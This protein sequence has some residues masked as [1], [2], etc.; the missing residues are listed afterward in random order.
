MVWNGPGW[1]RMGT[2]RGLTLQVAALGGHLA[3]ALLAGFRRG[4]LNV[5]G[6]L[7]GDGSTAGSAAPCQRAAAVRH[8]GALAR[9]A[10]AA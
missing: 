1:T 10:T 9:P 2:A 4:A 5:V 3:D 7:T 6:P 8:V